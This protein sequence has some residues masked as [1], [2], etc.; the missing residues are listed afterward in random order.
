MVAKKIG[1]TGKCADELANGVGYAGAA[2]ALL[3]LAKVLE[4]AAPGDQVV[5]A[6]GAHLLG[7][8]LLRS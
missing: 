3:M 4:T 2:H 5:V 8:G 7:R 1:F 6:A